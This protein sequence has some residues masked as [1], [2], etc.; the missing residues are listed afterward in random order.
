MTFTS[1]PSV[2]IIKIFMIGNRNSK[3]R[4]SKGFHSL[5]GKMSMVKPVTHRFLFFEALHDHFESD[6]F[7][8]SI[9]HHI[10]DTDNM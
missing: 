6:F 9:L 10:T 2:W 4:F 7:R 5:L 8:A 1:R 3:V